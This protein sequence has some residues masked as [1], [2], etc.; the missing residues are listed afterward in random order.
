MPAS[1]KASTDLQSQSVVRTDSATRFSSTW[2]I[3]LLLVLVLLY[4]CGLLFKWDSPPEQAAASQLLAQAR[5]ALAQQ[6][7]RLAGKLSQDV[8]RDHLDWTASRLV[9]GEAASRLGEFEQAIE[10]YRS[11]PLASDPD[12]LLARY[13]LAEI[14][15]HLGEL[16]NAMTAYESVLTMDPLHWQ[17][18]QKLAY[19]Y[20]LTGQRW[21]S[22]SHFRFLLTTNTASLQDLIMMGDLERHIEQIDYLE[23]CVVQAPD[24]PLAKLGVA[25]Y[26]SIVD[27]DPTKARNLLENVIDAHPEIVGAQ[28]LLGEL[29]VDGDPETFLNWHEHLPAA[30]DLNPDIWFVRGLWARRENE[31]EIAA[32]CFWE[33]VRIFPEHRRG[34]YHLGQI[35]VALG[36]TSGQEFA[37]RS[38]LYFDF[39]KLLDDVLQTQGQQPE[40]MRQACEL[41][42]KC[43]R[44]LEVRSWAMLSRNQFPG[45]IWPDQ[46]LQQ[47]QSEIAPDSPRTIDSANLALRY[48]LSSLPSYQ[49]LFRERPEH[50]L[51]PNDSQH[52]AEIKF[53]S[54]DHHGIQAIYHNG[55][56][57]QT[58]GARM[59]EQTGGGVGVIDFDL[60]RWPDLYFTQGGEWGSNSPVPPSEVD[61]FDRLYRNTGSEFLDVTPAAKLTD[62]GFGQ[63]P[64]VGDIENDGFPDLYVANIGRNQLYSNNGDGT[65]SD[66]TESAGL[67]TSNWTVS[68]VLVDLN[69]DGLP[70]IFDVNYLQGENV[71]TL[72]CEGHGC[73]PAVFQG[74]PDDVWLNNGNGTFRHTAN[75]TPREDAKGLGVVAA[76]IGSDKRI[77][78]FIAN[79][80]VPNFF[81]RSEPGD[82]SNRFQMKNDAFFSGLGYNESGLAMACMGIA[83]DDADGDQRLDFFVTN[84]KDEA[85]TLYLQDSDG[86]FV[87]ATNVAGLKAMSWSYVG[88]GT[89]FLDADLDG[90]SDL[91]IV[92][93]HVDDYRDEG[94]EFEM[95][96]QF[97]RNIGN[98]Q[99]TELPAREVG[100]FFEKKILGRG[101]AKLDWNRDGRP[102]FV[103]SNIGSQASL[104]TNESAVGHF[105]N[106]KL[107]AV[108]TARD[109]LGVSVTVA[110]G[111]Q[112]W[113]K[114]LVA[115]DGYQASNERVLQFGLGR[116]TA[117]DS[118]SFV[119]PSGATTTLKNL[120]VDITLE[121]VEGAKSGTMWR[122]T[123]P[124][125]IDIPTDGLQK[126]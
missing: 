12:T 78:L 16:S 28:A 41:L 105:F 49:Q 14:Y 82:D 51:Q 73:S 20:L 119:W 109:A 4:V 75:A 121:L 39:T 81:L 36:R 10:F 66:I 93:G 15:R 11:V 57:P 68:T 84:F 80:Q 9:A 35:L 112:R 97:C 1:E 100:K 95:L 90:H 91:V 18:H 98:G 58:Q 83:A 67:N 19:L 2:P 85:N 64:T 3:R 17:S 22:T 45:A 120:P 70:D 32:R 118:V 37:N 79:D 30:A 31:L 77:S 123:Q 44:R 21:E 63:G 42:L 115:G 113:T 24:D 25:A 106:L 13:S 48:D 71:F 94:G 125:S 38:Q 53:S 55:A 126:P 111:N 40:F 86:L 56:D 29:Y 27:G 33:T 101:L 50:D 116:E 96:P 43:G 6:D 47:V 52:V 61:E 59:F 5:V 60:D 62:R 74:C 104:V 69:D 110:A 88:W 124:A 89:Q 76:R 23:K 65:F 122:G 103:V 108:H 54:V 114:Q 7:F 8:P 92:N 34:N 87:D 102:D 99:F 72:I 117:V 107:H 46:Y 26:S